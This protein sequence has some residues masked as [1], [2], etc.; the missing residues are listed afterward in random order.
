MRFG[1]GLGLSVF[2]GNRVSE[3]SNFGGID[4]ILIGKW[5]DSIPTSDAWNDAVGWIFNGVWDD[6]VPTGASTWNSPDGTGYNIWID[7]EVTI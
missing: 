7:S 1:L 3:L 4:W 6:A 5:D 2:L